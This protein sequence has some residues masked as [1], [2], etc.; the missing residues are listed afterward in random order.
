MPADHRTRKK[1]RSEPTF[2]LSFFFLKNEFHLQDEN[3]TK[4]KER[5]DDRDTMT[6][7]GATSRDTAGVPVDDDFKR[8]DSDRWTDMSDEQFERMVCDEWGLKAEKEDREY[9]YWRLCTGKVVRVSIAP[10]KRKIEVANTAIATV[11]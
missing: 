7:S 10:N 9:E 8:I 5:G 4:G 3:Q 1:G 11:H 6:D 2:L